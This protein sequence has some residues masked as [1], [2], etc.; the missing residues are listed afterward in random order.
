[1]VMRR[2]E[3]LTRLRNC[4]SAIQTAAQQGAYLGSG[5]QPTA[6]LQDAPPDI[7]TTERPLIANV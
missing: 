3:F 4:F 7:I 2:L 6:E 1:L 5:L